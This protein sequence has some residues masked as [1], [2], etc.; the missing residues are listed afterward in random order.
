MWQGSAP[1]LWPSWL[2]QRSGAWP[3]LWIG[4]RLWVSASPHGK[5][6]RK[7]FPACRVDFGQGDDCLISFFHAAVVLFSSAEECDVFLFFH[8]WIKPK[9]EPI[10]TSSLQLCRLRELLCAV[11]VFHP[12][13]VGQRCADGK[14]W[15]NLKVFLIKVLPLEPAQGPQSA[16]ADCRVARVL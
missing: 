6:K 14:L 10:N 2:A 15:D 9:T 8:Q 13:C 11:E 7:D 16:E 4:C 5:V 12:A 1:L 3:E